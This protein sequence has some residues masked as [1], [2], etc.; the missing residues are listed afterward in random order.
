MKR[1]TR[2][3]QYFSLGLAFVAAAA[4]LP[5]GCKEPPPPP[6]PKKA[7]PPPPPPKPD[8]V[9]LV[10][11]MQGADPR[12]QF[13]EDKAPYDKDLAEAVIAFAGALADGDDGA[14]G[15]ALNDE[16]RG[17]LDGMLADGTWFESTDEIEAVR[18]VYLGQSPDEDEEA[19]FAE[20]VLAVQAPDGAYTL[21][22]EAN[23]TAGGW[24]MSPIRTADATL[25]RASD[26]DG[27]SIGAYESAAGWAGAT[28]SSGE[29]MPQPKVDTGGEMYD[30]D[31]ARLIQSEPMIVYIDVEMGKRYFADK[32]TAP[33][34]TMMQVIVLRTKLEMSEVFDL[35]L[36]GKSSRE[37]GHLPD[38]SALKEFVDRGLEEIAEVRASPNAAMVPDDFPKTRDEVLEVIADLLGKST[39]DIRK[40]YDSAP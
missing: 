11:L 38:A 8:R 15:G 5:A 27:D 25:P 16:G 24:V 20:F 1:R 30:A 7:P 29:A 14:F 4:V 31:F 13:P 35:Y 21:G 37:A 2:L 34:A 33:D 12:L 39:R 3:T 22:W 10:S 17:V 23:E 9:S 6:P 40:L 18:V 26:W 32:M 28:T 36:S 19:T